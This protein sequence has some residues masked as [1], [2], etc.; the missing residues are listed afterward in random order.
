MIFLAAVRPIKQDANVYGNVIACQGS[1][2][3]LAEALLT[4]GLLIPMIQM[5]TCHQP[6]IGL[7]TMSRE[8]HKYCLQ[9]SSL[10]REAARWTGVVLLAFGFGCGKVD[11]K[12]STV[13]VEALLVEGNNQV[14]QPDSG[15]GGRITESK[16]RASYE[17][18][19]PRAAWDDFPL[20]VVFFDN[21][22]S[23]AAQ[24]TS[25]PVPAS[26]DSDL[27]DPKGEEGIASEETVRKSAE[28]IHLPLDVLEEEVR[29]LQ[30]RLSG[31]M[32]QLESYNKNH[33]TIRVDAATLAILAAVA[34]E[35]EYDLKWKIKAKSIRD[36]AML[37]SQSARS[38]GPGNYTTANKHFKKLVR[39]LSDKPGQLEQESLEAAEDT[40]WQETVDLSL[41]MRRLDRSFEITIK[42]AAIKGGSSRKN[43][44]ILQ[45]EATLL[46]AFGQ[47]ISISS[48]WSQEDSYQQFC[49]D[50]IV[51]AEA[52]VSA[53]KV[54]SEDLVSETISKLDRSC[55][56]CHDE[57]RFEDS[58]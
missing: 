20:D 39:L 34:A 17:V 23:L 10:F 50:L 53:V 9:P 51:Q 19:R 22:A 3:G 31:A 29:I 52:L 46:R 37:V 4:K 14:E 43:R 38:L 40:I 8:D 11:K 36:M 26:N 6:W 12:E 13:S 2:K 25:S 15:K 21:P 58:F 5:K 56:N 45:H 30:D 27:L 48:E 49:A 57:Y 24:V 41:L 47:A 28:P 44:S 7:H 55:K 1:G 35:S 16:K 54:R 32:A 42:E 18:L 33:R